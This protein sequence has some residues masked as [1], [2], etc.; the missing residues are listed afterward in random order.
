MA[1]LEAQEILKNLS[2]LLSDTSYGNSP[3]SQQE[4]V[5]LSKTLT[6]TIEPPENVAMELAFSTFIPMSA[7]IAVDL[8]L[9][10]HI[11]KYEPVN[12]AKLAELSGAEELLITMTQKGIAAGH[13]ILF[14]T[15]MLAA[16]H[17]P[18]YFL[19]TSHTSPTN[20]HDGLMQY[21]HGTKL[22]S[23]DYFGTMPGNVLGDFNTFMGNT[24]GARKYWLDWWPVEER[25]FEGVEGADNALL[26][27][28]GGG[29]GHDVMAFKEKFGGREN[30]V[31]RLVLQDQPHVL[32]EIGKG[33]LG[34][35]IEKCGY[36]FFTEQPVKNSR[37]YFYHHI[38]HDWSDYKCLEILRVLKSAMKPNYSKLIIHEM[39]VPESGAST[40]HA[41]LDLTMMAFN[42]GTE[43]TGK[44]WR[45]YLRKRGL[46][47]RG[48]GFL[49]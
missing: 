42:G 39:I 11:V 47:S 45:D 23:F 5:R 38:L 49:R 44:E 3:K 10:E 48:F 22:Q 33:E 31:G 7:R 17:A 35:G 26:V 28:V 14:A 16:L 13:R 41:L 29:K 40:Y 4:A 32:E 12:I 34:E 9:F 30:G 36:D 2:T 21:A 1:N 27:D 15:S 8:N 20:P 19:E 24:M 6:A 18:R 46:R 25:V 43:R 37:I